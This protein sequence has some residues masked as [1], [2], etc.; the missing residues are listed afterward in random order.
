MQGRPSATW[1]CNPQFRLAARKAGELLL[2]LSQ[3]DPMLSSGG[4]VP[5]AQREA[6]VGFQARHRSPDD[7]DALLP[8]PA[9][10]QQH[11]SVRR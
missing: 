11:A 8:W 3:R 1:C 7:F 2:C 10:A 9:Q 4:H 5:K 6:R